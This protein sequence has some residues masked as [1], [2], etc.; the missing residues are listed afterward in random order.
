MADTQFTA[1]VAHAFS[2]IGEGGYAQGLNKYKLC[3]AYIIPRECARG[4]TL[5]EKCVATDR[6]W[7]QAGEIE[8]NCEYRIRDR[9]WKSHLLSWKDGA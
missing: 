2:R 7:L 6:V 3:I 4:Y 1:A 5:R 8:P 9:A